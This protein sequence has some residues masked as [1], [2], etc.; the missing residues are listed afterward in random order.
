M[1]RLP[2]Y[3]MRTPVLLT[4][5]GGLLLLKIAMHFYSLPETYQSW[6][7]TVKSILLALII[8]SFLPVLLMLLAGIFTKNKKEE[9]WEKQPKGSKSK[10]LFYEFLVKSLYV[11]VPILLYSLLMFV[12][13]FLGWQTVFIYAIA[14]LAGKVSG[15]L[16]QKKQGGISQ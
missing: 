3:L 13:L 7:A 8:I 15:R 10:E 9:W 11:S 6:M 5:V 14:Y 4:Y 12:V 2:E 1:K 16:N